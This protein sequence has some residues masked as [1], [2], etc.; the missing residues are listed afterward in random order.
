MTLRPLI[1][2]LSSVVTVI[3]PLVQPSPVGCH[4]PCPS[5]GGACARPSAARRQSVSSACAAGRHPS[6]RPACAPP[7]ASSCACEQPP[8]RCCA[9]PASRAG[10]PSSCR[11]SIYLSALFQYTNLTIGAKRY[12]NGISITNEAERAYGGGGWVLGQIGLR[13][14]R[15]DWEL[16]GMGTRPCARPRQRLPGGV[17]STSPA[18]RPQTVCIR[19]AEPHRFYL[20]PHRSSPIDSIYLALS[21]TLREEPPS[22]AGRARG[23]EGSEADKRR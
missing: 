11:D 13:E 16:R 12:T 21:L 14:R 10:R 1:D 4:R 3:V 8:C 9:R 18:H 17:G 20:E 7:R 2:P 23:H 22:T 15:N 6:S 5:G 19:C